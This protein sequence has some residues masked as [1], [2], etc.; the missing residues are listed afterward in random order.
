MNDIIAKLKHNFKCPLFIISGQ[1]DCDITKSALTSLHGNS[2]G[3]LQN[4]TPNITD[5]SNNSRLHVSGGL[6]DPNNMQQD[7]VCIGKP[8]AFTLIKDFKYLG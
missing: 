4:Q 2:F 6:C 1:K 5:P 3:Q 7:Q 8:I